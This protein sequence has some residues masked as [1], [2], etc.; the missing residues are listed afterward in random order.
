MLPWGQLQDCTLP[1]TA[2][3]L[4]ALEHANNMRTCCLDMTIPSLGG[5]GPVPE[6]FPQLRC[7]SLDTLI[8]H[9]LRGDSSGCISS[10]FS[11]L[12]LPSLQHLELRLLPP[13]YWP[14]NGEPELGLTSSFLKF[15]ERSSHLSV[16]TLDE[17]P[18]STTQLIDY[19]AF[20]PS[21]TSLDIKHT[22]KYVIKD[23]LLQRLTLNH[24]DHLLP[25]LGTLSIR[26]QAELGCGGFPAQKPRSRL[27]P[28]RRL[29]ETN[30]I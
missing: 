24:T 26:G 30:G 25:R 11:S 3:T 20:M 10:F 14:F 17:L 18:A 21:L 15:F 8:I 7:P 22:N 6:I 28:P 23:E 16:L 1:D 29:A 27:F 2:A 4:Y 12:T 9:W 5:W 19:L 13:I